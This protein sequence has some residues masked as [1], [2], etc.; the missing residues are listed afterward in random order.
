M[1]PDREMIRRV[2]DYRDS[3]FEGFIPTPVEYSD[4]SY[5]T[6][7]LSYPSVQQWRQAN[8]GVDRDIDLNIFFSTQS[9]VRADFFT[10]ID[11]L[12]MVGI[13]KLE[14][15]GFLVDAWFHAPS[16][17]TAGYYLKLD[18]G[19]RTFCYRGME[20]HKIRQFVGVELDNMFEIADLYKPY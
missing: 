16:I 15:L 10:G 20:Q 9:M 8:W 1:H 3:L 2:I 14:E 19:E 18:D 13:R 12:P 4:S 17:Q 11:K 6:S 5:D 7:T